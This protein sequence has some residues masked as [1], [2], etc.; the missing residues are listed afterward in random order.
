MSRINLILI[1]SCIVP[2]FLFGDYPLIAK[3]IKSLDSVYA[4][5][6]EDVETWYANS[7]ETSPLALFRYIPL[8]NEDLFSVAAAFN[9]SYEA[10]ATLNGW[11]TPVLFT[12]E[13]EILVPNMPGI[14]LPEN[15]SGAWEEDLAQKRQGQESM[16]IAVSLGNG[17][18]KSLVFYAGSKFT[19]Q[20][21]IKFLGALFSTPIYKGTQSS[22]FGYRPHPFTGKTSFHPGVDI[23]VDTGTEVVS[24]RTGVVSDVGVL[25]L[26]GKYIIVDHAGRYQSVYAHLDE[27]LV[28]VGQ[29]VRT[30]ER[31]A[32]SG[33]SGISTGPHLHFEIRRNGKPIDPLR[34]TAWKL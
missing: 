33:N 15:P 30:G 19:A 32:L 14:F 6:Q 26:Y 11:D 20:E 18:K 21:R 3:T 1:I 9:L 16:S 8:A 27:I 22:G 12:P 34:I 25:E 7:A 13:K 31:I 2:A 10:L 5:Q 4:Q 28:A 24:A 17:G 29:K 23:E